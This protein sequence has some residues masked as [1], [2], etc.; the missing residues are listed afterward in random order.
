MFIRVSGG[1]LYWGCYGIATW[2]RG[3][4]FGRTWV[5]GQKG[6]KYWSHSWIPLKCLHDFSKAIFLGVAIK[7]LLGDEEIWSGT[8]EKQVK[9]AIIFYPTIGSRSNIYTSFGRLFALGLLWNCYSVTRRSGW[10]DLSNR[11]KWPQLL[12][13]LLDHAQ[14]FTWFSGGRFPWGTYWIATRVTEVWSATLK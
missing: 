10:L 13:P 1:R 6:H 3:G 7:S 2:W 8:L 14:I 9:M 12:I 4:L 5:T 11:S